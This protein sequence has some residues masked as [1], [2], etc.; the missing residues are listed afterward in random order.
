MAPSASGDILF[1]PACPSDCL[2]QMVSILVKATPHAN[3][4]SIFLKLCRFFSQGS[5]DV[6]E[7]WL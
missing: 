4:S 7:V 3:F 5:E 2:S 6:H 1:Y